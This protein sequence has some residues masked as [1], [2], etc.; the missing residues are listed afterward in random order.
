MKDGQ[1]KCDRNSKEREFIVG[2]QK[3]EGG[4]WMELGGRL[5]TGRQK[6]TN[7]RG[8]QGPSHRAQEVQGSLGEC[9]ACK[10]FGFYVESSSDS[11]GLRSELHV[12]SL[13]VRARSEE[14]GL[15]SEAH[16]ILLGNG[17]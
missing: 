7:Q 1:H 9:P 17:L 12:E 3:G 16:S 8:Q 4:F 11:V 13:H 5:E 10:E 2:I 14:L 15:N 6:E